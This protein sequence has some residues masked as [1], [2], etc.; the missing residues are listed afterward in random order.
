MCDEWSKNLNYTL[1][2]IKDAYIDVPVVF[3]AHVQKYIDYQFIEN[4]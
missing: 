3:G 1:F 4:K 2:K